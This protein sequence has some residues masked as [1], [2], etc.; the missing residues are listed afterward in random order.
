MGETD[1]PDF[2][3]ARGYLIGFS[4]VV[5][6]LWYFGADLSTFKLL[7]NEIRL[8]ENAQNVWMVLGGINA[9]LWLRL[10]QR[11]PEGSFRFDLAMH[12]LYEKTLIQTMKRVDKK[13]MLT[14]VLEQIND[15]PDTIPGEVKLHLFT[16]KGKMTH[17]EIT[18]P[19][20]MASLDKLAML[21]QLP[22]TTRNEIRYSFYIHY[23]VS[24]NDHHLN[25]GQA[26][27]T[28]PSRLVAK[29]VKWYVFARGA[30]VSPW[31]FDHVTPFVL[32]GI[33]I[34]VAL[35]NWWQINYPHS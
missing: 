20:N 13:K 23:T 11:T 32:G 12:D 18:P 26:F 10:Y 3:K 9:Y 7:G 15:S 16:A 22:G 33:S 27:K 29:L 31:F 19:K 17:Y 24:G 8:K 21:R 6:L 28:T 2:N 4:T 25:A 14:H 30:I 5:L 34:F 1:T 35:F